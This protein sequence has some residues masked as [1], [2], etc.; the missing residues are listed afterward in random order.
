MPLKIVRDD[1]DVGAGVQR[2][3]V[4]ATADGDYWGCDV[5]ISLRVAVV[6]EVDGAVVPGVDDPTVV[7]FA[8]HLQ[9]AAVGFV[10]VVAK[11]AVVEVGYLHHN[12]C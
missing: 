12:S 3:A 9:S 5:W 1:G 10:V 11:G 7:A 8:N 6:A 4:V 2:D